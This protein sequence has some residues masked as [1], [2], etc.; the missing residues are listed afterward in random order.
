MVITKAPPDPCSNRGA[1]FT[2]LLAG[3]FTLRWSFFCLF[4]LCQLQGLQAFCNPLLKDFCGFGMSRFPCQIEW[5]L[6]VVAFHIQVRAAVKKSADHR[7]VSVL[8]R[9]VERSVTALFADVWVCSMFKEPF[10]DFHMSRCARGL[11]RAGFE[12]GPGW[13]V[14]GGS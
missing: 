14:D 13:G 6:A 9:C 2:S 8:R 4:P 11:D 1:F 10:Y 7:F 5:G 3:Q 12:P